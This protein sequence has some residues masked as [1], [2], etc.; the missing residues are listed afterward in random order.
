MYKQHAL[1]SWSPAKI[2]WHL[3]K[4]LPHRRK[5]DVI[6]KLNC[7]SEVLYHSSI[8]PLERPLGPPVGKTRGKPMAHPWAPWAGG[9]DPGRPSVSFS[10]R[11]LLLPDPIVFLILQHPQ[12]Q[13]QL[14]PLL[15]VAFITGP[16]KKS[17]KISDQQKKNQSWLYDYNFGSVS[18]NLVTPGEPQ[19]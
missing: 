11:S 10:K 14:V 4:S 5:N 9:R 13:S 2:R 19:K 6:F 7:S 16:A 17:G 1:Y 15:R 12:L 3:K 8:N 18:K